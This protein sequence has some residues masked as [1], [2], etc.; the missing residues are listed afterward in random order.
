MGVAIVAIDCGYRMGGARRYVHPR[1]GG[2]RVRSGMN[3]PLMLSDRALKSW[4]RA[5][6]VPSHG[7]VPRP[8]VL[9]ARMSVPLWAFIAVQTQM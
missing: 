4:F 7:L 8:I 2:I 6:K 9:R 1:T 5:L 3:L